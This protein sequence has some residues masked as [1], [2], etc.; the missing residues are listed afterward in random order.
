[1]IALPFLVFDADIIRFFADQEG[2]ERSYSFTTS[3]VGKFATGPV[4]HIL[5][6]GVDLNRSESRILTLFGDPSPLNIFDPIY[7]LIPKPSRSDLPLF[8]DTLTTS[9]RLGIYL[10]DQIYLLDSLILVAGLRYETITQKITNVETTFV[11]GGETEKTDDALTPRIG[12]LYR[13]I[14]ELALFA[15]YS[16]SFRPSSSLTAS[17][18]PLRPEEGEGFE[19]GVKTELLNQKLLA[20]L[21]YF[22]ITKKNVGVSDPN[23]PLFSI[24]TGEQKSRG[25]E[26]DLAGEILPGWKVISSYAYIDAKIS[27]DTDEAIVGKRLF[28]IPWNKASLWS[29]YEI[30]QGSLKGLGFGMGFEYVGDRFGDLANSFRVGDYFLGNAAIYYRRDNYRFA[31][32]IRNLSNASYIRSLTGNEGGIEPGAPLTVIGSFSLTF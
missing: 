15:N 25:V 17:G 24:S 19:V 2:Q 6:A 14:P 10:Q 26:F 27:N 11:A 9:N 29:T 7:D 3:A 16:Q 31:V 32:N 21:T 30:Q 5:T 18:S 13:P 23:N 12:L 20:T 1:M 28:G 22:D 8:A 4:K